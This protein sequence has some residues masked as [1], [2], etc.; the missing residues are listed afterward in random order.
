[1]LKRISDF[2]AGVKMTA[3]SGVCLAASLVMLL[4]DVNPIL[5][6]AW[7]TVVL[8][9]YP[10]LYLALTR[11]VCRKMDFVSA[12]DLYGH[13]SV[14]EHWRTFCGGGKSRLLWQSARFWRIGL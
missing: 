6:P 12:V 8:S 1:M 14:P 5:D 13:G 2:F 11:L 4:A 9:G 7:I 10:L 3:V